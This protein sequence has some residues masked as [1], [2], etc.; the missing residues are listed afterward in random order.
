MQNA[1]LTNNVIHLS[2]VTEVMIDEDE[3][4]LPEQFAMN[5]ESRKVVIEAIDRLPLRQRE[6]VILHYYDRLNITE[7]AE[8]MGITQPAASI[9]LKEACS[10]IKRDIES[11]ADKLVRAMQGFVAIPFGD[12][13]TRALFTEGAAFSP[14]TQAWLS[15]TI[16]KCGD[17]A[18]LGAAV[19][20]GGASAA[21][22][23]AAA[24]AAAESAVV[25]TT[26]AGAA[27]TSA[28][29]G[30]GVIY[31]TATTATSIAKALLITV[32]AATATLA[33]T[34]G[35][36][37][38]YA[39]QNASPN[40]HAEGVITFT[41]AHEQGFV[42]PTIATASSKSQM[43][44]LYIHHWDIQTT[45]GEMVLYTGMGDTVDESIFAH[46]RENGILG[47]YELVFIM[48]DANGIK[49]E[50]AHNFILLE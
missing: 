43:G 20:A 27:G 33:I 31:C 30:S 14:A 4:F 13:L 45:D 5:A 47:E 22:A 8:V 34:A 7:T 26:V 40:T 49:Y 19:A 3:D 35:A 32:A 42:N 24:G 15:E 17:I 36:I 23:G 48:E 29:A 1:K 46:M 44:E 38:L 16:A 50:L 28:A 21:G 39:S 12:M 6:A 10:R 37:T 41:S 25:G 9:H 18:L 11:S 2:E